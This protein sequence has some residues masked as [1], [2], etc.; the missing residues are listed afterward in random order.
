MADAIAP[1]PPGLLEKLRTTRHLLVFTGAGISAESGIST[2]RDSPTGLWARF[3]P[4][5]LATA[6]AFRRDPAL[7]WGWYEWR[8]MKVLQAQPN[9]GHRAIAELARQVPEFSLLTQN[10]DDLH[11]RAG[12]RV[13]AHLHGELAR[14]RCFDCGRPARYPPGIPEEPEDGR[15]LEPLRCRICHGPVRPGVVWFGESLPADAWERAMGAL[16]EADLVF[17]VGTSALVYPAADIPAAAA[18]RGATVVQINPAPTALDS[19]AHYN[20]AGPAGVILPA[21]VAAAFPTTQ[22]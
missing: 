18:R 11:E 21:L 6:Q 19:I 13:L 1:F 15:R 12:S 4:S 2:F 22:G 7:V 16:A 5:E 17:S 14:P 10:V 9:P 8:R 20:L 3:D